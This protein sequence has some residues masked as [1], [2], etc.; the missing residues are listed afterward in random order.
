MKLRGFLI[1][2]VLGFAIPANSWGQK[3]KL[4]EEAKKILEKAESLELYS[5]DPD[6]S[7]R[8]P[9]PKNNFHGWKILGKTT[10]KKA[11][12]RQKLLQSLERGIRANSGIVAGCFNPRHGIRATLKNETVDVVICFQCFSMQ[13]VQG[14][15]TRNVLTTGLPAPTFNKILTA[16]K[17]PL[18][19]QPDD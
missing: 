1:L 2:F 7:R 5:L 4:P 14:K 18:P 15:K 11:E 6:G 16:A 9:K 3:N 12:D 10:I 8:G 19:K 13:V 17:V